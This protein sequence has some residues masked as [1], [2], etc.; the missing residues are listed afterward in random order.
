M[1]NI[2]GLFYVQ[3]LTIKLINTLER[4]TRKLHMSNLRLLVT[5]KLKVY[6]C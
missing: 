5:G 2:S 4:K 1:I 6:F 3:L